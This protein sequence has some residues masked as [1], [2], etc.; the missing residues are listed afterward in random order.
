MGYFVQ[1]VMFAKGVF[2]TAIKHVMVQQNRF[3]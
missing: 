3:D 2:G 1:G